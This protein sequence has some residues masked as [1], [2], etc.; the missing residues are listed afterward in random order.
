VP[1][2]LFTKPSQEA[3][4]STIYESINFNPYRETGMKAGFIQFDPIFGEVKINIEKAT[5]LIE[6][7]DADVIVLPEFFNTGYL[8]TSQQEAGEMAEM[9]P[10]GPTTEA[11]C[12]I[13][14]R[15]NM[16]IVGGKCIFSMRRRCGLRPGT[17]DLRFTTSVLANWGS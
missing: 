1:A 5:R 7:L 10:D 4:F 17:R 9:I 11:L 15:K 13:A 14:R 8:F 2:E 12:V 6:P 3:G 16:H